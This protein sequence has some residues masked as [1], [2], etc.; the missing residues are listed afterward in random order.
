[1]NEIHKILQQFQIVYNGAAWHGPNIQQTL[2]EVQPEQVSKRFGE[3]KSIAELLL[4]MTAWRRFVIERL[5]GNQDFDLT[6]PDE[7]FPPPPDPL[8]AE[9][10]HSILHQLEQSQQEL[11]QL[12]RQAEDPLLEKTVAQRT[13]NFYQ[14]LHGVLQ[15]DV[16]HLGQIRILA[17]Y[18]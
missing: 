12:L 14:L 7:N 16:Y 6:E 10:W 1:M 8:D 5:R 17:K 4:H 2:S 13:Y 15:H 11:I 9:G 3:S 18:G